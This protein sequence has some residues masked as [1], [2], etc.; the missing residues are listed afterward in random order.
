MGWALTISLL[1]PLGGAERTERFDRDPGWEGINNRSARRESR[2]VRQDFGFSRTSHAGGAAGEIGGFVSP[3]AEPAWYAKRISPATFEQPLSASGRLAASGQNFHLLVGFFNSRSVNEWRTPNSIALRIMG[4]GDVFFAYVEYATSKWRAGGDSP[5]SFPMVRD[6]AT[7]RQEPKGFPARGAV[8]PWSLRYDPAAAGG[9]GAITAAIGDVVAIC[10]LEEGHRRDGA[11]FDRF[12]LLTVMKSADT[13]GDVWLDDI[14]I[15]GRL[16][17]L[18]T[19][20]GWDGFQNRQTYRTHV[21]RPRFDFGFSPTHFAGGKA[22][23]ELG[24]LIFR[25]DCRFADKLASYADRLDELTLEKPIRASGRVALRRGVSDSSV[26]VG[27]FDSKSSMTANPSQASGLPKN[28]LGIST[29]GPSREGFYFSPVCRLGGDARTTTSGEPPHIL[30]DGKSHDWALA[31]LP[32]GAD[33]RGEVA[34]TL[35]GRTV[36]LPLQPGDRQGA[37]RF[38]RFGL[39]TTWVDGNS[40]TIFFDDLTY[41]VRQ[42]D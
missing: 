3:A 20:A 31:Y 34:A 37:H 40:Q 33:G 5:K 32:S 6:P 8:H 29:D 14:T 28:F 41:T 39:V 2:K 23:G 16:D 36:R 1:G 11:T 38:D 9:R 17:D 7:G 12:G 22:S 13:G 19:D 21:V 18:S 26:L 25:G 4:R 42:E 35:D 27:F 15:N 30:P 10:E 24:G